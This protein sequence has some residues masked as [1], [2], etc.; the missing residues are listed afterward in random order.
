MKFLRRF[1]LSCVLA[2]LVA[3]ERAKSP[4]SVDS[5]AILAA[6]AADSAAI[7]ASPTRN[8]DANAGP[9]LLVPGAEPSKALVIPP[10]S[11]K[12]AEQLGGIPQPAAVTLFGRNGNVQTAELPK[13]SAGDPCT[14]FQLTAAPPPRP[15]NVGFIG[16]VVA[17]VALDSLQSISPAD[18]A[19]LIGG[20]V[21]AASALPNDPA[22]RFVGL[23]L[24]IHSL[25]RFTLSDGVQVIAAT[26]TRQINQE[27]TP[28]QERTLIVGERSA[29]DTTISMAYSERSY[30]NEETI[31]S[32]DV[33]AALLVGSART[34][35][36][37]ISHDFGDTTAYGLVERVEAGHWR[38]RWLSARLRCGG[39]NLVDSR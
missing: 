39:S 8:W 27:A 16:G 36:L 14:P 37:I 19:S 30:G 20:M 26:F 13:V 31:E 28:L 24:V 34:P 10:D 6:R 22:G 2:A 23:P 3:C 12:S 29:N 7:E 15:W 9:V 17:P 18:S 38:S 4:P 32:Q 5:S 11:A 21:R 35:A 25:W 33:V 1:R